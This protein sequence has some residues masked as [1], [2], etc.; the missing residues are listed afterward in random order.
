M[1]AFQSWQYPISL[2]ASESLLHRS[3]SSYFYDFLMADVLAFDLLCHYNYSPGGAMEKGQES[4]EPSCSLGHGEG[5]WDF[6][7]K[8]KRVQKQKAYLHIGASRSFRGA[9]SLCSISIFTTRQQGQVPW[10]WKETQMCF[11][12]AT[13]IEI[14]LLLSAPSQHLTAVLTK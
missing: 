11:S 7:F 1:P 14:E 8:P 3:P 9:D 6:L 5:W 4:H 2:L 12:L 10:P 13:L